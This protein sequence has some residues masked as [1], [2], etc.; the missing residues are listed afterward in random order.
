MTQTITD[1]KNRRSIRRYK[2]DQIPKHTIKEIVESAVYAP[3][4]RNQQKWHFTVIQDEATI[5]KMVKITKENLLNSDVE[6]L[7]QRARSPDYHTFS[8]APTVIL[9]T[10]EEGTRFVELDCGAAMQ[11]ITLAAESLGVGSCIIASS[12]FLFASDKEKIMK[13]LGVPEGYGHI[14]TIALGYTDG[15]KPATPPRKFDVINYI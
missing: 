12:E 6:F 1:I 5:T 10:A 2:T 15:E 8:N 9:V 11:N 13:M 7:K 14:C 4:S 3:N